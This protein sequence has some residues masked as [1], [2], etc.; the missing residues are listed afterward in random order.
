MR[1][2]PKIIIVSPFGYDCLPRFLRLASRRCCSSCLDR[3]IESKRFFWF[4]KNEFSRKCIRFFELGWGFVNG[5]GLIRSVFQEEFK[6]IV[7]DL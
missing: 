7:C 3:Q 1:S 5:V 6:R 2:P 4:E